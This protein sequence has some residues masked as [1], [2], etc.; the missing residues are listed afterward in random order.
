M[1]L[2]VSTSV[3]WATRT[4]ARHTHTGRLSS[5]HPTDRCSIEVHSCRPT[6]TVGMA[7][8]AHHSNTV[9]S[10]AHLAQHCQHRL[11]QL[12]VSCRF[13]KLAGTC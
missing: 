4:P 12:A 11:F 6:T 9:S 10:H 7:K 13:S 8:A 2:A 3:R 5:G 1:V